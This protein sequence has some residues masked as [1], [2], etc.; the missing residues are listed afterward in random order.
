VDYHRNS[1]NTVAA[2]LFR[3]EHKS[4]IPGHRQLDSYPDRYRHHTHHLAPAWGGVDLSRSDDQ[5]GSAKADD[6]FI[7]LNRKAICRLIN[8]PGGRLLE[9]S[10]S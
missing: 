7:L 4:K 3:T 9:Y 2:R 5:P 1:C 8:R 10:Y 6:V